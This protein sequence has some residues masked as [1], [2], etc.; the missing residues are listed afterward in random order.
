MLETDLTFKERKKK[1]QA[2][3]DDYF[4]KDDYFRNAAELLSI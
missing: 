1:R 4:T 2:F 3:S